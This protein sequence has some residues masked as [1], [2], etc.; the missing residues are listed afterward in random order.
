MTWGVNQITVLSPMSC[1]RFPPSTPECSCA[2]D[3]VGKFERPM[4]QLMATSY[5]RGAVWAACLCLAVAGLAGGIIMN[6]GIILD[7]AMID[8]YGVRAGSSLQPPKIYTDHQAKQQAAWARDKKLET[9]DQ[10]LVDLT[11]TLEVCMY[12]GMALIR[13]VSYH[14]HNDLVDCFANPTMCIL[15]TTDHSFENQF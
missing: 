8:T 7:Y 12:L 2:A 14:D 11:L 13:A 15:P 5:L 9:K 4:E 3:L 10:T 6:A 1:V